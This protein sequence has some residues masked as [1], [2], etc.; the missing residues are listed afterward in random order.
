MEDGHHRTVVRN[1]VIQLLAFNLNFNENLNANNSRK[2]IY[3]EMSEAY[4]THPYTFHIASSKMT[5]WIDLH[6]HSVY[7]VNIMPGEL[8]V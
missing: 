6:G 1:W 2:H 7:G 3:T 5:A 4:N 8:I